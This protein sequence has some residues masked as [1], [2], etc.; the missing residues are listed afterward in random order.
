MP[1]DYAIE[2]RCSHRR[3]RF[4]LAFARAAAE[5]LP[6]DDDIAFETT[7]RGL[8]ILAETEL[9]LERPIE[10]LRSVYGDEIQI[11]A[12]QVRYRQGEQTE[13]PYMG[14]RLLCAAQHFEIF[15]RDLLVRGAEILDSESNQR[16]GVLRASAPLAVLV[17]YP[18][19]VR[20]ISGGRA[21][22]AMWLSHYAPV[23]PPP[24]AA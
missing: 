5:L 13:E 9:S 2:C 6:K 19:H 7:R 1:R 11:A 12:P 18:A 3:E 16:F 17:G 4:Q 24:G 22:L 15:R 21:K 8:T 20:E 14:L 23:P 10:R